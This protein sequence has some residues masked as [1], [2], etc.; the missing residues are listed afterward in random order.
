[1]G[2][3]KYLPP[4]RLDVLNECRIRYSQPNSFNDPFE[5]KPH[6]TGLAP[7]QWLE[8]RL[9]RRF[10]RVV[11]EQYDSMSARFRDEVSLRTFA[12]AIDYM[13]PEVYSLFR[14]VDDS[15]VPAINA[16]MHERFGAHVAVLS[17]SEVNDC[18]LMWAHY[19]DSHRG[20]VIEFDPAHSF[21]TTRITPEDEL[22]HLHKVIYRNPRPHTTVAELDFRAI[23]LTKHV[24]WRY[25]REWR[26]F[27]PLIHAEHVKHQDPFP[28]CLYRFPPDCITSLIFGARMKPHQ[29]NEALA[30]LKSCG[31]R[32]DL[33]VFEAILD[34]T[35][36]A[37]H[38]QPFCP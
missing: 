5:G 18:Q 8:A 24:S 12:A 32:F 38:I 2:L 21:F 35:S 7:S 10:D 6:Y 1:M 11:T 37:M 17:L 29:R 16:M 3:F 14:S 13:R 25:E 22:W 30:A 20:F 36:Y 33:A 4:E 9:P 26:D 19:A 31:A 34:R 23:L 15:F 27:Q 28:I